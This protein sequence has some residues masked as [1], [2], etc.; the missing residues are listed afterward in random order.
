MSRYGRVIP[1]NLYG[2]QKSF[3]VEV[4]DGRGDRETL[5][6]YGKDK[7]DAYRAFLADV[8]ASDRA[9]AL[10]F[11]RLLRSPGVKVNVYSEKINVH[12]LRTGKRSELVLHDPLHLRGQDLGGSV[13]FKVGRQPMKAVLY[14]YKT[15]EHAGQPRIEL[16][17]ITMSGPSRGLEIHKGYLE[18][19]TKGPLREEVTAAIRRAMHT[20]PTWQKVKWRLA[21]RAA[22]EER[23]P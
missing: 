6:I 22:G 5:Y 3:L 10:T 14:R 9:L 12:G 23:T 17:K 4:I 18:R 20:M 21:M 13:E 11:Q 8:G 7:D 1:P 19:D 15:G 16:Y 2:E